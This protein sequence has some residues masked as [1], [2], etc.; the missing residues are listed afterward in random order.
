MRYDNSAQPEIEDFQ[1]F[2]STRGKPALDDAHRF[3]DQAVYGPVD[4][5]A[6]SFIAE[7]G[8]NFSLRVHLDYFRIYRPAIFRIG[9]VILQDQEF[10][11]S[12]IRA[13]RSRSTAFKS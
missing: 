12:A 2:A 1:S 7:G 9:A 5:Q 6:E 8:A 11:R 4:F 13:S 3:L 10:S